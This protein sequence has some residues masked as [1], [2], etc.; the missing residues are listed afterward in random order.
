[1]TSQEEL[2]VGSVVYMGRGSFR[3]EAI[4]FET[5]RERGV[6]QPIQS[7]T[8]GLVT[9][10]YEADGRAVRGAGANFQANFQDDKDDNNHNDR[11]DVSDVTGDLSPSG[12]ARTQTVGTWQAPT[13][14]PLFGS[15][16]EL[17]ML[18]APIAVF[19]SQRSPLSL[20][21]GAIA[22]LG[23]AV[24]ACGLLAAGAAHSLTVTGPSAA[25]A[26]TNEAATPAPATPVVSAPVATVTATHE[27]S[28]PTPV[29]IQVPAPVKITAHKAPPA[30]RAMAAATTAATT[31]T[32]TTT[33]KATTTTTPARKPW[34]DPFA[35]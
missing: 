25:L 21:R 3:M 19:P 2:S 13:V 15:R 16:D 22:G 20:S 8:L 26:A 17:P 29:T 23:A 32:T 24:F 6:A 35:E 12:V 11:I 5:D 27:A 18:T 34:V 1:V 9:A 7:S 28:L 30:H 31:T 4:G 10:P 14:Q 33:A